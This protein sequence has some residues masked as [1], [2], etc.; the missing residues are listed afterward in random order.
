MGEKENSLA[1]MEE[2]L[3]DQQHAITATAEKLLKSEV[4]AAMEVTTILAERNI[5]VAGLNYE[6]KHLTDKLT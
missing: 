1:V 4:E 5:E 2:R 3:G 6:I